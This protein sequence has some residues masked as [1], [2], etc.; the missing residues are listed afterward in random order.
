MNND[1]YTLFGKIVG[2]AYQEKINTITLTVIGNAGHIMYEREGYTADQ[3]VERKEMEH[4]QKVL[5]ALAF[6]RVYT[7][8][9]TSLPVINV[10]I[11]TKRKA[12]EGIDIL[13]RDI[14]ETEQQKTL[15]LTLQ[16]R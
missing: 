1:R 3:I 9:K 10:R 15:Q 7:E 5:E 6:P 11:G 13:I 4:L 2:H 12:R 14:T 16:Y 8:P